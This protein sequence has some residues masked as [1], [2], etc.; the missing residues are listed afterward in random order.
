MMNSAVGKDVREL[1][2]FYLEAGVDT[3]IGEEPIDRFADEVAQPIQP[4]APRPPSP[5]VPRQRADSAIAGTAAPAATAIP[6]SPETAIMAAREAAKSAR[7]LDELRALLEAFEGCMLRATATQLVFA[8]GNPQARVMFVGEAPGRDEDISGIPF[9]GRSGQLLDR[10]MAAIGLDR[11][12]AYIANVVP[13]R[14]PGNR[15]PTPQETAICL[16]FIRRQIELANPDILVCL[17]QPATQTLLGNQGGNHPNARALVQVR[18]WQPRDSRDGDLPSCLSAAQPAA[19]AARLAGFSGAEESAGRIKATLC[20]PACRFPARV[21]SRLQQDQCGVSTAAAGALAGLIMPQP[22][23]RGGSLPRT[24][25]S[26][27]RGTSGTRSGNCALDLRRRRWIGVGRRPHDHGALFADVSC[28]HPARLHWFESKVHAG[29]AWRRER[30]KRGGARVAANDSERMA[31][32]AFEAF[33]K[34][35]AHG[36]GGL[37]HSQVSAG[38]PRQQN[39]RGRHEKR[40]HQQQAGPRIAENALMMQRDAVAGGNNDR[41]PGQHEQGAAPPTGVRSPISTATI[42]ASSAGT[43]ANTLT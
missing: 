4:A 27:V 20:S 40:G 1:V 10:M 28:R 35:A 29:A 37:R 43:N 5:I 25:R 31:G 14:P 21:H 36:G 38:R 17:G 24:G 34:E 12:S 3:L 16:P 41:E 9:V 33:G 26:N 13:W 8:A 2:A 7:T 30:H 6:A 39:D 23:S 22:I 42:V 19:K 15:T 32:S 11:T 18:Y